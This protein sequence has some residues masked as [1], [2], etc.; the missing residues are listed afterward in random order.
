MTGEDIISTS[1]SIMDFNI[2]KENPK[3]YFSTWKLFL[4]ACPFKEK[5]QPNEILHK[6]LL[7]RVTHMVPYLCMPTCHHPKSPPSHHLVPIILIPLY[8]H[9]TQLRK[10]PCLSLCLACHKHSQLQ[11]ATTQSLGS[12]ST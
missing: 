10:H 9:A 11:G 8:C 5:F 2:I 6:F 3:K 7:S 12:T 4:K 1:K